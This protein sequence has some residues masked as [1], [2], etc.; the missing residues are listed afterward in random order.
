MSSFAANLRRVATELRRLP[1]LRGFLTLRCSRENQQVESF[2][3]DKHRAAIGTRRIRSPHEAV[4]GTRQR[5]LSMRR[6]RNLAKFECGEALARELRVAH[7]SNINSRGE[8]CGKLKA[9][10]V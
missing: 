3:C 7:G 5:A 6:S 8:P 1:P 4:I 2:K 9:S 10:G